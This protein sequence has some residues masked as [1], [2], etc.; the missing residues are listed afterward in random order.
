MVEIF[1]FGGIGSF[2]EGEIFLLGDGSLSMSE[3]DQMNL[4]LKLK[5]T[6][7][8]YW[9]TIKITISTT[10]MC[11]EYEVKNATRA[12]ATAK[13]EVFWSYNIKTVIY[14]G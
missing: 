14:W 13:Y 2:P 8:Q 10:Y 12:I 3:F 4:F 5:T 6:F 11:K 1:P 7:Y 9:T